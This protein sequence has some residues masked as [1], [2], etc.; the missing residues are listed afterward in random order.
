MGKKS[1][2]MNLEL[3]DG[4]VELPDKSCEVIRFKVS[5]DGSI[6]TAMNVH[7][8]SKHKMFNCRDFQDE[9]E[10]SET[11]IS[12]D[13]WAYLPNINDLKEREDA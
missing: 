11:W 7:F 5:D 8:S 10:A 6:R 2:N 1:M 13:Y 3:H 4:K 12:V 9:K